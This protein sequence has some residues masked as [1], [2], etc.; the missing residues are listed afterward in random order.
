MLFWECQFRRDQ[1]SQLNSETF[2]KIFSAMQV[3]GMCLLYVKRYFQQYQ[4]SA[5]LFMTQ[6]TQILLFSGV[7]VLKRSKITF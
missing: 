5:F 7:K 6:R 4:W 1:R 2:S 3:L